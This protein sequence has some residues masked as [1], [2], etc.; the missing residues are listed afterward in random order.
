MKLLKKIV[1]IVVGL[2]AVIAI[3][4]YLFLAVRESRSKGGLVHQESE[5]VIKVAVDKILTDIAWN[6]I[7]NPGT[8]FG[9]DSTDTTSDGKSSRN[10][11]ISIP[12]NVY[13]F[14]LKDEEETWYTWFSVENQEQLQGFVRAELGIDSTG[15]EKEND[16]WWINGKD[17]R[18][19]LLG[20]S[21]NV[22]VALSFD[23]KDKKAAMLKIWEGRTTAMVPIKTLTEF[24][25]ENTAD[26]EWKQKGNDAD[27][28]LSFKKGMITANWSLPNDILRLPQQAKVRQLPS[29]NVLNMYC[30]ADIRPVLEKYENRLQR[31]NIP[32]D[33]L[34]NYYGGYMDIQWR[35][36][37]VL[38]TDSIIAYD[39]DENFNAIEKKEIREEAVPN[40][41]FTFNASPHLAGYLPEKMFYKFYKRIEGKQIGLSTDA[42]GKN[43]FPYVSTDHAFLLSYTRNEAAQRHLSWL[44]QF[45]RVEKVEISGRGGEVANSFKGEV[46]LSEYGIHA[47]YQLLN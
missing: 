21:K 2:I 20:D 25:F 4:L 7:S 16:F 35:A 29:S 46:K 33:T 19:V 11:G 38:Q 5:Y 12:A 6:A 8:Y 26:I 37:D 47:L 10:L 43:E 17:N 39:Y 34:K 14:A 27:A 41:L 3:G 15:I 36:N 13:M 32:V 24:S 45:D 9:K 44:S 1:F 30:Q 18:V 31:Y 42:N 40:I 28:N 23:K 22:L